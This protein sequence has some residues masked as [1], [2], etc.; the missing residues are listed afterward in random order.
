MISSVWLRVIFQY[1]DRQN[2]KK[3]YNYFWYWETVD[4]N[5]EYPMIRET[6]FEY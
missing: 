4:N 5:Y 3:D 1:I 2:I 6:N